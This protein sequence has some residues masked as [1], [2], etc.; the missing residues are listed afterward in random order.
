MTAEPS[1]PEAAFERVRMIHEGIE[2]EVARRGPVCELS[3][4]CCRFE[5]YGHTLFLSVIEVELLARHAPPPSRA[6]DSG[7]T[8]PWQDAHGR[9]TAREARPLGCRVYFCDPVYELIAH[10]VS[11][12]AIAELKRVSSEYGVAWDYQPLHQHLG[13]LREEGRL[14]LALAP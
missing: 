5:E 3:G 2:A 4:R 13:R 12:P 9:C 1:I 14:A 6:L 8:C 11:E 10:E 7:K